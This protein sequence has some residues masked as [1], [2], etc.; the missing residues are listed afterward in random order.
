MSKYIRKYILYF[1]IALLFFFLGII[2]NYA[3]ITYN[4]VTTE[5]INKVVNEIKIEETAVEEAIEKVYNAV[6]VV[7]SLKND[8]TVS[9]GTGFVYKEDN[10]HG[11]IIT[12]YHVLSDG[13]KAA[14]TFSNGERVEADIL[15]SDVYADIAV[16]S[17]PKSKVIKV[18]SIGS[19][20]KM[21]VGNTVFA[22]GAPVG[23]EYSG[24][25]TKGIISNKERFVP[26]SLSGSSSNDWLMRVIQTD[27]AINPGNSGGPLV[28]I[29]GEVIGITSLKLIDSKI[30]G[31]GFAIPIEDAMLYVE[32]LEKGEVISRPML[33]VQLLDVTE[34]FALF[35]SNI[36]LDD[37]VKEG[38]VIQAVIKDSAATKAGLKKGDVIL[39][40]GDK[41]IKNKAELRYELYKYDVGSKVK[42][43]YYRDKKIREVEVTLKSID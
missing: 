14:V 28:N 31:I 4:P 11:Y 27:A 18:A 2:F 43:T 21:A 5:T 12:N 41:R 36:T 38:A 30:E 40:I 16:L 8:A 33:G 29:A 7:E 22:I 26:I 19:S 1:L 10:K 23:I 24:T 9:S 42:I 6:V 15:G 34:I 37:D 20:A 13:N 35:Y 25:V 3:Y 39:K 17:V 32:K